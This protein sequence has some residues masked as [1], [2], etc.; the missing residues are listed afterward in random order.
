MPQTQPS[1]T[2]HAYVG[3][4]AQMTPKTPSKQESRTL[5]AS[6]QWTGEDGNTSEGW[7]HVLLTPEAE[8]A[9][10]RRVDAMWQ[11]QCIINGFINGLD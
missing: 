3:V 11:L 4:V 9:L 1:Y 6:V 7:L 5:A 2:P 10:L 8:Q